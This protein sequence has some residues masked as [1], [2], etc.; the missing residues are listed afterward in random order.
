M[1][2]FDRLL[3]VFPSKSKNRWI[4][5]P[6]L[7]LK[8][9]V[10]FLILPKTIFYILQYFILFYYIS[11][12]A[13]RLLALRL[14]LISYVWICKIL[15][16]ARGGVNKDNFLGNIYYSSIFL[17]SGFLFFSIDQYF[18]IWDFFHEHSQH[19]GKENAV[20][21]TPTA[22]HIFNNIHLLHK[23]LEVSMVITA[24]SSPIHIARSWTQTENLWFPSASHY[25]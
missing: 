14:I 12:Y 4:H 20:S 18:F 16:W 1:P 2:C 9:Y 23:H 6:F 17:M 3:F 7:L 15:I 8:F 25:F 11:F 19:K 13:L 10:F 5:I 22:C 24:E 21:L